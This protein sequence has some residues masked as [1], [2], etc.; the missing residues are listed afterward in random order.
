MKKLAIK[1]E[2]THYFVVEP[3]QKVNRSLSLRVRR[4][5]LSIKIKIKY[6]HKK[7]KITPICASW[8][9]KEP[10]LRNRDSFFFW[11]I[12]TFI[13]NETRHS[14]PVVSISLTETKYNTIFALKTAF[15]L[16]YLPCRDKVCS[17][18]LSWWFLFDFHYLVFHL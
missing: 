18:V 14:K 13:Q 4:E 10:N 11:S 16:L 1:K 7:T 9:C 2:R 6:L 8:K 15:F 17:V 3:Q 5:V 12:E